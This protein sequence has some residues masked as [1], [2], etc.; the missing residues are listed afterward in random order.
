MIKKP[1]KIKELTL[2]GIFTAVTAVL[3]QVAIPLP[4]TPMPISF[5]LVAVYVSGILLKP[6]HAVFAQICYLLLGAAGL[7]VFANFRG[8]IGALLGPTGGYLMV[9]P[10]MAGLV[11]LALNSR[12]GMQLGYGQSKA[13][14]FL[15]AGASMC[16]AHTLL[17]LGGTGWFCLTTGIAFQDALALTVYPFIP[18]DAVKI[19]FCIFTVVPMR[20]RM[21]NY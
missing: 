2:I 14:V 3:A 13:W 12:I 15:K 21:K 1:L 5:G 20:S 4:F 16:L 7:P 18:L 9:Y 19:A 17:Y 8:G 11:S 10:V 6:K